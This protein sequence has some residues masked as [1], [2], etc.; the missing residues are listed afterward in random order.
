LSIRINKGA[1]EKACKEIIETILFCLPNA[2]KG[3]VYRVGG[4]PN[5]V[6][7]RVT[8][9]IIDEE[10]QVISWGLPERSGYNYPGKR[11]M[12]YRD[13][14]GR[15]LEA[16]AWCVEKQKSWTVEDPAKDARSI[17]LQTDGILEDYHHMEPVLIRK[18]DLN[19]INHLHLEYPRDSEGRLL[20]GGYDYVV[21]A[22]I[23]I[24]FRPNTILI[25][26]PET[27]LIKRLSR[28]FGTELLSY[29]LREES[30]EAMRNL[31]QD[32]LDSCNILAD[33]LR[34]AIMKSGLIFSLIK[35]ELGFLRAQWEALLFEQTN[36][37]NEKE[38]A[39]GSLNRLL[40]EIG[41]ITGEPID[42]LMGNQ[43]KFLDFS[44]PPKLGEVWVRRQI[45]SRWTRLLEKLSP[46]DTMAKEVAE[47][48]EQL[49]RSLH[50]G[51][52]PELLASYSLM[53]DALKKEW[54]DL[55]Y[56]D[57]EGIDFKSLDRIIQILGD[58]SLNLP[59][60]EKSRK[61]LL[62]LKALSE[63]MDQLEN[64]TNVVLKQ[65]LNGGYNGQSIYDYLHSHG[66][67]IT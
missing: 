57:A 26:G 42:E 11:W 18:K 17:R 10:K 49:K 24:H 15:P 21:A 61:S 16:M 2:F 29:Q 35:V 59:F 38:E 52:S 55:I 45:E 20:W 56:T 44:L 40:K 47:A 27:Q 13:Q 67:G 33:S 37:R 31:A 63:I 30:L 7:E 14:P 22:I 8:S 51:K 53:P 36:R 1:L 3:T 48:L 54:V 60:Q 25:G 28:S 50:L 65:L 12:D 58:L 23:K 66:N 39:I 19:T 32:K 46:G 64:S 5:I 62:H 34:N 9:G 4:P 43:R 41:R 6:V